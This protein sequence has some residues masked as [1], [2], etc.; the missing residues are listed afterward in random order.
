[1][2]SNQQCKY[3]ETYKQNGW[4]ICMIDN[5]CSSCRTDE[6]YKPKPTKKIKFIKTKPDIVFSCYNCDK[7]VIRDSVEH[8]HSKCDETGEIWFCDECDV[9][10]LDIC[11]ETGREFDRRNP[12]EGCGKILGDDDEN[13]MIG[14]ISFCIQ[15]G[16]NGMKNNYLF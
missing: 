4:G 6:H 2:T 15:C 11:G 10:E 3:A 8:D 9:Q 13:I 12:V 14:N 1:M 16:E 5:L 7:Y